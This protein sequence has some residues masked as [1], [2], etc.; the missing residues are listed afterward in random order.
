M[1]DANKAFKNSLFKEARKSFIEHIRI[2]TYLAI[3]E[4]GNR[5]L[6]KYYSS[7]A[8]GRAV[9]EK[10]TLIERMYKVSVWEGEEGTTFNEEEFAAV[11]AE[12]FWQSVKPRAQLLT[13]VLL[14]GK[15]KVDSKIWL[16][17]LK[18]GNGDNPPS[19]IGLRDSD[20]PLDKSLLGR[21]QSYAGSGPGQCGI[22]LVEDFISRQLRICTVKFN[23]TDKDD[24][25]AYYRDRSTCYDKGKHLPLKEKTWIGE[26][27]SGKVYR[28]KFH[29]EHFADY[30]DKALAMKVFQESDP[31]ADSSFESE[32]KHSRVIR[33][34]T[35]SHASILTSCASLKLDKGHGGLLFFE[36]ADYNLMKYMESCEIQDAAKSSWMQELAD[37]AD[38]L[39]FLHNKGRC[40]GDVKSENILVFTLAQGGFKL[41]ITD[42]GIKSG[43][44]SQ[45]SYVIAS[46]FSVRRPKPGSIG[47]DCLNRAP[48]DHAGAHAGSPEGRD[49][50]GFGTVLAEVLA[51]FGGRESLEDFEKSRYGCGPNDQYYELDHKDRPML[52]KAV[53]DWFVFFLETRAP[54]DKDIRRLYTQTWALLR[55][56]IFVVETKRRRR[57]TAA[58]VHQKLLENLNVSEEKRSPSL[59]RRFVKYGS[60]VDN[61]SVP[62]TPPENYSVYASLYRAANSG[63][64][65]RQ[66]AMDSIKQN[67][68]L[69][70][71]RCSLENA[72]KDCNFVLVDLLRDVRF[73]KGANMFHKAVEAGYVEFFNKLKQVPASELNE[74]DTEGRT[75][76]LKAISGREHVRLALVERLVFLGADVNIGDKVGQTPLFYASRLAA[77]SVIRELLKGTAGAIEAG[78]NRA[79]ANRADVNKPDVVGRTPLHVCALVVNSDLES[80]P[81]E[82]VQLLLDAGADKE[83]KDKEGKYPLDCALEPSNSLTSERC[84]IV[85]RL[86]RNT[87]DEQGVCARYVREVF[88]NQSPEIRRQFHKIWS[89]TV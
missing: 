5:K 65:L 64:D 2:S 40:H 52:R 19:L 89:N 77:P 68:S 48:E 23:K 28:V 16:D 47:D 14:L 57:S 42:F 41:K 45:P 44:E 13:I 39:S 62:G 8:P 43:N 75:P 67:S 61:A 50:W 38:A 72:M 30:N 86:C 3:D 29:R 32:R 54:P 76:L 15:V 46:S 74:P 84:D 25:D 1:T 80:D 35:R 33:E 20:L 34:D 21:L 26:G 85:E 49:I 53:E 6:E 27:G 7:S 73:P 70:D 11:A 4:E 22:D 18:D 31:N 81:T 17:F 82:C 10:K 37:V 56:K 87:R 66:D 9:E 51:W 59:W 24:H 63:N 79:D 60:S 36:L 69:R 55:N 12:S 88:F 78:A 83:V 58:E 71:L